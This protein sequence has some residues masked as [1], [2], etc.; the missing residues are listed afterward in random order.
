MSGISRNYWWHSLIHELVSFFFFFIIILIIFPLTL[1][2]F[3]HGTHRRKISHTRNSLF[4]SRKRQEV[5]ESDREED[6][7]LGNSNQSKEKEEEEKW[8]VRLMLLLLMY[9]FTCIYA[10]STGKFMALDS[11]YTFLLFAFSHAAATE[12]IFSIPSSLPLSSCVN[13]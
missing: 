6:G 12:T 13:E 9:I 2:I 5:G 11:R 4:S 10:K 8:H 7:K 3:S 1:P